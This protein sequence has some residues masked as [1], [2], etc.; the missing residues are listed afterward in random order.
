M[1]TPNAESSAS[2]TKKFPIFKMYNLGSY[3]ILNYLNPHQNKE[4]S[5]E[6]ECNEAKT[7]N[8]TSQTAK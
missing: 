7:D 3:N 1:S 5:E 2:F 6:I 8:S 4:V